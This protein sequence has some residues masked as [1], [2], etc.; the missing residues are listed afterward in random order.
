[1]HGV[2]RINPPAPLGL[3]RGSGSRPGARSGAGR[4]PQV[5]GLCGER[6]TA[7][8]GAGGTQCGHSASLTHSCA[9]GPSNEFTFIHLPWGLPISSPLLK[10]GQFN[11]LGVSERVCQCTHHTE[12]HACA[13]TSD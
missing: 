12:T 13:H 3:R 6:E 5:A 8:A 7:E 1:M 10:A 2:W 4:F 9:L 11:I